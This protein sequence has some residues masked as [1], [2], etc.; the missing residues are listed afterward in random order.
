MPVVESIESGIL[1]TELREA[2]RTLLSR[3]DAPYLDLPGTLDGP[4][5]CISTSL[6][7][8]R[9][10]IEM[11]Y[12]EKL[13]SQPK[14]PVNYRPGGGRR[15]LPDAPIESYVTEGKPK[16]QDAATQTQ[17]IPE[18]PVH[19]ATQSRSRPGT[20]RHTA[21]TESAPETRTR[22]PRKARRVIVSDS[23]DID[24]E[25]RG[26]L[27]ATSRSSPR[28]DAR[29]GPVENHGSSRAASSPCAWEKAIKKPVGPIYGPEDMQ[30][31]WVSNRSRKRKAGSELQPRPAKRPTMGASSRPEVILVVSDSDADVE[32]DESQQSTDEKPDN[33]DQQSE[34]ENRDGEPEV[35]DAAPTAVHP[36]SSPLSGVPPSDI[37]PQAG[38]LAKHRSVVSS[39]TSAATGK[40]VSSV[41]VVG[42][43]VPALVPV[44]PSSQDSAS[45]QSG[46]DGQNQAA[47]IDKDARAALHR[48][49][50]LTGVQ[51]SQKY[52]GTMIKQSLVLGGC[53][54]L[55]NFR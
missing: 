31:G 15:K 54:A 19:I 48:I 13:D 27:A 21:Q 49:E 42:Q 2:L 7:D 35:D 45:S 39:S 14:V 55:E 3:N 4:G 40:L 41:E 38:D 11:K 36:E 9:R 26:D 5:I 47:K 46:S 44:I 30:G 33:E 23:S 29:H 16:C 28:S 51:V 10:Y 12:Q 52:R 50:I 34:G 18:T 22:R 43:S 32:D 1:P 17:P 25:G 53:N 24:T 8:F 37:A 6:A 20:P